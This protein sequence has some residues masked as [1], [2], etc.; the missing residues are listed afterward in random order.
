MRF[1]V[2]PIMLIIGIMGCVTNSVSN[3]DPT[4]LGARQIEVRT[5]DAPQNIAYNAS[6]QAF[7]DLGYSIKHTDKVSG[8]ITGS[9][10]TGTEEAKNSQKT[11]T[12]LG[13][14]PYVGIASLLLPNKEP[15]VHQVTMFLQ[16]VSSNQTQIRFKMQANGE[17]TWDS[18]AIDQL[19]VTTQREA[20]LESGITSKTPVAKEKK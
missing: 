15:T 17:A 5:L 16:A 1:Y 20:M 11:K 12:A 13:F 6:I 14:V 2:L 4:Q 18:I 3:Q 19:W 8:V 9:R 7:F 10:T